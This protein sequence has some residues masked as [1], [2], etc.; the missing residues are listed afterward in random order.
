MGISYGLICLAINI[1]RSEGNG[2][3]MPDE[4]GYLNLKG[5]YCCSVHFGIFCTSF[6]ANKRQNTSTI[7]RLFRF[8]RFCIY[9][10][11]RIEIEVFLKLLFKT[12]QWKYRIPHSCRHAFASFNFVLAFCACQKYCFTSQDCCIIK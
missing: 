11:S 8:F 10:D 4:G 3:L 1:S 9:I 5:K 2:L 7:E 6:V 12:T